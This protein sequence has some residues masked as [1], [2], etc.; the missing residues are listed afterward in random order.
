N[1]VRRD[2][3]ADGS[4][5]RTTVMLRNIPNKLDWLG[6]KALLDKWC[7]GTYDFFYL[8]IDFKTGCNVG[9]AF[10]NF[11]TIEG[12]LQMIDNIERRTWLGF[13]SQKAAEISYATIQ[14]HEAL[15][16]KFQ[17]SNINQEAA[18]C[19]PRSIHSEMEARDRGDVRLTGTERPLPPP[20]NLAKLQRSIESAKC[21]GLYPPTAAVNLGVDARL[22]T[23]AYDNG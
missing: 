14:G 13:R 6:L 12:L 11:A 18:Y 5:V 16:Q 3:V 19:R 23:G 1:R 10:I 20:D 2:K 15:E 4:D 17:N 7:F 21:M 9:Y 22:R 8:R